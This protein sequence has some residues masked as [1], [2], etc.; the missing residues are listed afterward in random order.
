MKSIWKRLFSGVLAAALSTSLFALPASAEDGKVGITF[1]RNEQVVFDEDD[2]AGLFPEFQDLFPGDHREQEIYVRNRFREDIGVTLRIEKSAQS[3]TDAEKLAKIDELLYG[4]VNS[5]GSRTPLLM[6]TI[7]NGENKLYEGTIGG[8]NGAIDLGIL[9]QGHGA[10]LTIVL[11]VNGPDMDDSYQDLLAGIDILV[12]G[13]W[14]L[15]YVPPTDPD[16]SDEESDEEIEESSVPLTSFPEDPEM[17]GEEAIPIPG[18]GGEDGETID[19]NETPLQP[20]PDQEKLPQTG[21]D[22]P[23]AAVGCGVICFG[24]VIAIIVLTGKK[25]NT[26]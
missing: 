25:K 22:F 19:E 3:E 1:T 12:E 24:A 14:N 10:P 26:K 5:D 20:L 6:A 18:P 16:E 7:Y 21:D 9:N 13:S 23:L 15:P 11:D 2:E 4:K 8:I 17:S